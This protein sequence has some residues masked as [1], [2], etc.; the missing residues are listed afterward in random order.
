VSGEQRLRVGRTYTKARRYPWVIGRLGDWTI[1]FGPFT[2]AQVVVLLG[3]TWLLAKTFSLWKPLGPLPLIGLG[4]LAWAVR[5]TRFGGRTPLAAALGLVRV[6]VEPKAGRIGGKVA[7]DPRPQLL[8]GAFG[9]VVTEDVGGAAAALPLRTEERRE[10]LGPLPSEPRRPG[11]S[12]A[13]TPSLVAA[14]ATRSPG[15]SAGIN[16]LTTQAGKGR[17]GTD[18][19]GITGSPP[20]A[21]APTR[22]QAMLAGP[23]QR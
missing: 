5:T 16:A 2:P 13:V 14:R 7:R 9:V 11:H 8:Q 18:S 15:D 12:S 6:L 4:C 21:P 23:G 17:A 10:V 22:L 3:G 1:P 20:A 19:G